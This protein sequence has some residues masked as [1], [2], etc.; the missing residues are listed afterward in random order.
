MTHANNNTTHDRRT[1]IDPLSRRMPIQE[2]P[3]SLRSPCCFF[4]QDVNEAVCLTLM[5]GKVRRM[6]LRE[7]KSVCEIARLTRLSSN[8]TSE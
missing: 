3:R 6:R 7:N 8:T 5:T 4:H 1:E 2:L